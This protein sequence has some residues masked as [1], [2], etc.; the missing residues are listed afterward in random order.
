MVW[1]AEHQAQGKLTQDDIASAYARA[2]LA[3]TDLFQPT[4]EEDITHN[5][6]KVYKEML[7]CL[8]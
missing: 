7:K 2:D 4:A 8:D 1:L 3:I 5:L 6:H